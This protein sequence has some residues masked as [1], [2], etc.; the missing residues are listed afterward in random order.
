LKKIKVAEYGNGFN[1]IKYRN[2]GMPESINAMII[3]I[4]RGDFFCVC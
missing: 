3:P 4:I 2:T 1:P